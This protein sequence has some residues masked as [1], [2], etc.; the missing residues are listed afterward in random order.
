[1][2]STKLVEL[3]RTGSSMFGKKGA[4]IQLQFLALHDLDIEPRERAIIRI[5][6]LRGVSRT[7]QILNTLPSEAAADPAPIS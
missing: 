3:M 7:C 5:L 1:M 6:F 4:P 2:V